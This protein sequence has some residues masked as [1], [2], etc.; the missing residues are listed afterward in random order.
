[1]NTGGRK[2]ETCIMRRGRLLYHAC[3]YAPLHDLLLRDSSPCYFAEKNSMGA[4]T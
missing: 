3:G 1:M 4:Y 2:E